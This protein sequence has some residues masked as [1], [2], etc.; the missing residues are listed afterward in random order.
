MNAV[1]HRRWLSGVLLVLLAVAPARAESPV[2]HRHDLYEVG[3]EGYQS[4]RLPSVAVLDDGTILCFVAGRRKVSDWADMDILLTRSRDGGMSW[5][6]PRLLIRGEGLPVDNAHVVVDRRTGGIHVVYHKNFEQLFHI[7]SHDWGDTFS[8]PREI[9]AAVD[10]VADE[11]YAW[12]VVSPTPGSSAQLRNGRM[13]IPLWLAN[14]PERKHRPSIVTTL[15]S[16]DGG[17]TWACGERVVGDLPEHPNPSEGVIVELPDGQVMMN[18]RC[19]S[20]RY[21]RLVTVSPD[22]V[23]NWSRPAF[24][25]ALYDPIC[26]A[27]IAAAPHPREPGRSVVLFA[28]PDARSHAHPVRPNG[29]KPRENMTVRV[30]LDDGRTWPIAYVVDPERSAYCDLAAGPG[31]MVYLVYERGYQPGNNLNTRYVTFVA[32]SLER[33]LDRPDVIAP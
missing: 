13:V 18:V 24:D 30:S 7:V 27:S 11:G 32:L 23:S 31:G 15:Y 5:S 12:T 25:E 4:I 17:D 1:W 8:E 16:D 33:L 19:E 26:H 20:M 2:V 14:S 6:P 29:Y 21:R 9:T 22:G 3:Y 28:N 10:R